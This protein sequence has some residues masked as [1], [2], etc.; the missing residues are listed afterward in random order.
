M[1]LTTKGYKNLKMSSVKSHIFCCFQI[2]TELNN[3][4]NLIL[5]YNLFMVILTTNGEQQYCQKLH[6]DKTPIAVEG[7]FGKK[8]FEKW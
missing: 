3:L 4:N 2:L 5:I 7:N 1:N 8:T 6:L